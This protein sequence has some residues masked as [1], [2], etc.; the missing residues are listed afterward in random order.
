MRSAIQPD[1]STSFLG[2]SE[3]IGPYQFSETAATL[4]QVAAR[5][6]RRYQELLNLN[7]A[8]ALTIC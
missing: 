3:L 5:V 2:K 6:Y 8:M 4:A 7:R 1:P